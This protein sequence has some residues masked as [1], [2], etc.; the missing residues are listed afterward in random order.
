LYFSTDVV[1]ALGLSARIPVLLAAWSPATVC[2]LLGSAL[3]F[4]FED[5]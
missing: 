2:C 5:G 1:Y 3:L 4:H